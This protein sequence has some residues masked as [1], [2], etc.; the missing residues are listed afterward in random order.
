M[1]KLRKFHTVAE[2]VFCLRLA[3]FQLVNRILTQEMVQPE[4]HEPTCSHPQ[5]PQP[6]NARLSLQP[7]LPLNKPTVAAQYMR[8]QPS[9]RFTCATAMHK[10]CIS[11]CILPVSKP[12]H[13]HRYRQKTPSKANTPAAIHRF[14]SPAARALAFSCSFSG[15]MVHLHAHK[16]R[17]TTQK[18]TGDSMSSM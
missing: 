18:Q 6:C 4:T 10:P 7:P 15:W 5:V 14:H 3:L 13:A 12:Y 11:A 2:I 9:I 17:H 1:C 8:P 16:S